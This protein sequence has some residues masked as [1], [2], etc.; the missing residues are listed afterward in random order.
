MEN[1]NAKDQEEKE[2]NFKIFQFFY[3]MLRSL[4]SLTNLQFYEITDFMNNLHILNSDRFTF[5]AKNNVFFC[6]FVKLCSEQFKFWF[7]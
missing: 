2:V 7:L 5:K 1:G 6:Y 4:H 3:S